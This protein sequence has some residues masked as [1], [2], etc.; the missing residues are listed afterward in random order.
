MP[1]LLEGIRVVDW[2]IW[3][4]GPVCSGQHTDEVLADIL[5]YP[6]ARI[7]DLRQRKVV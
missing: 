4:Q 5:E 3:Q 1:M 7:A 2:R 6:A